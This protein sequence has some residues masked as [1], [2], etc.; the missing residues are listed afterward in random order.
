MGGWYSIEPCDLQPEMISKLSSSLSISKEALYSA[1]QTVRC[2]IVT[3]I[4]CRLELKVG[5]Q[6]T[7]VE[8]VMD[9]QRE[10]SLSIQWLLVIAINDIAG[11]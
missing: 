3:G 8:M 4:K 10:V 5:G 9:P 11:R 6:K 1:V 2:Q 7:E